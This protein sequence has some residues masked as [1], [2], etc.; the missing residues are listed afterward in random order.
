M[1]PINAIGENKITFIPYSEDPGVGL[2]GRGYELLQLD[3]K[4]YIHIAQ[5]ACLSKND[6]N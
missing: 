3:K 5:H 2:V 4:P 1:S 6:E